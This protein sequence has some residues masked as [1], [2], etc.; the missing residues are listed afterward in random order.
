MARVKMIMLEIPKLLSIHNI[1][2]IK[3]AIN[4]FS[5]DSLDILRGTIDDKIYENLDEPD[6]SDRLEEDHLFSLDEESRTSLLRRITTKDFIIRALDEIIT[7]YLIGEETST[8]SRTIYKKI[9]TATYAISFREEYSYTEEVDF[10]LIKSLKAS[11]A[12]SGKL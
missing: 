1:I 3:D 12:L 7:P 2:G 11:R 8:G 6:M 9:G 10:S 5:D 4:K